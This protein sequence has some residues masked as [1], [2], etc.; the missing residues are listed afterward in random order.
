MAST[1]EKQERNADPPLEIASS[2]NDRLRGHLEP[3][4][5][6]R[7]EAQLRSKLAELDAR[8]AEVTRCLEAAET[9]AAEVASAKGEIE[10]Q[11]RRLERRLAVIVSSRSWRMTRPLRTSGRLMRSLL[12]G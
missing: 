6:S 10:A 7:S 8:L 11:L 3:G 1:P 2:A 12:R 9:R 5:T 4:A